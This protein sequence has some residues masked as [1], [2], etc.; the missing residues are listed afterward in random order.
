VTP[1]RAFEFGLLALQQLVTMRPDIVINFGG[2]DVSGWDIPFP[3]VNLAAMDIS[4]LNAV[5]NRC[6]AGLVLSLSNM[7][8]LPLELL[9]SGVA[10]VVNDGPN[11]RL[12]SDNPFIEYVP[13]SPMAIARRIIDVLDRPDA[14]ERVVEMSSSVREVNWSESGAQFVDAFERAMRG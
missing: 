1:R 13:A 14:A 7:S 10:P 11:N 3:H 5:Y 8:L 12:V 9:S 2:W 6:A 4:E